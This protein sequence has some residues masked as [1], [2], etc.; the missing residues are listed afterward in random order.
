[1]DTKANKEIMARNIKRYMVK[2]GLTNQQV[3]DALG[4]KYTTFRDWR[5]ALTYPRID[6]IEAMANYFGCEKSDLIEEKPTN[7]KIELSEEE[8]D[9]IT[10]LRRLDQADYDTIRRMIKSFASS[11]EK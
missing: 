4:F 1:M 6:K 7:S 8:L 2:K 11:V 9:I 3:C 5:K 10:D